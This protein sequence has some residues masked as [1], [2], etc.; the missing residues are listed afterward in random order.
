MK[1]P[2]LYEPDMNELLREQRRLYEQGPLSVTIPALQV[3][4]VVGLVQLAMRHPDI[5]ED[6]TAQAGVDL[7]NQIKRRLANFP[8]LV[9]LI[10]AGWNPNADH[11]LDR[12]IIVLDENE[13]PF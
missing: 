9:A 6:E 7:I 1:K 5:T 10:D 13:R 4:A 2:L 8:H 12:V 3:H 11:A